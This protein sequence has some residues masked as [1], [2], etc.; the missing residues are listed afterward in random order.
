MSAYIIA[1]IN[2]TDAEDYQSYASQTVALAEK[3][4]GRFLAKG[5]PQTQLEGNSPDR[6]V[7]I[8]FPDRETALNWYNS[9]A[10]RQILP[11]AISSSERDI[12]VVDG[13]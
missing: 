11:I 13:V 2:V 6:H 10:Y 12:V 1:R 3:F 7:I 8:E 4:G 5:G 9:D